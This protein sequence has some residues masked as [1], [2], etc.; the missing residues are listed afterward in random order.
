MDSGFLIL[1][2]GDRRLVKMDFLGL[3]TNTRGLKPITMVMNHLRLSWDDPPTDQPK[4]NT[5]NFTSRLA[6]SVT[7]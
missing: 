6:V 1:P 5:Q 2:M 3:T 7:P 4:S